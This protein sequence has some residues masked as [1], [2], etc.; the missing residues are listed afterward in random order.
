MSSN[1]LKD[2]H[3]SQNPFGTGT[4]TR[5]VVRTRAEELATIRGDWLPKVPVADFEVAGL[6]ASKAAAENL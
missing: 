3:L 2:G 5:R 6:P 4:V 1:P